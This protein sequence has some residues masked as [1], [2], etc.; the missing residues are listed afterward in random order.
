[1]NLFQADFDNDGRLDLLVLRG[2]WL[3]AEGRLRNSQLRNDLG[4]AENRFVDVTALAGLAYPAYP[5]QAAAWADYDSDG[6]LD[7]FIGNEAGVS[8]YMTAGEAE[9]PYPSQLFRNNGDGTFTDIA[10]RAGVIN[11]RFAK[12]AAWGDFDNDGDPDLYVSNFGPN[13]LFRNQ[14]DATFADVAEP[15]GVTEPAGGSFATW[16][17]DYDNDGW[18]DIFVADYSAPM[19]AIAASH[20]G[21]PTTG[22]HPILYRNTGDGFVDVSRRL[23][24]EKPHLPMGA[25][26]GDL[27]KDGWLDFYLGTGVPNFD[28]LMPNAMY[29]NNLG[30][31]FEDVSYAGGFAHLQKG[32]GVAFG[33]LDNDGDEDLFHQLGGA[34]PYDAYGNA[35]FANPGNGNHWLVLRLEGRQANRFGVGAR[36]T[37][38]LRESGSERVVHRV[39]GSGG[40][41]GGSSLQQEIGL[42]RATA[43]ERVIVDWPGDAR[44]SVFEHPDPD[45][46]YLAV[47]G[48]SELRP[49][50]PPRL[51]LGRNAGSRSHHHEEQQP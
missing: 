47:E 12:G 14:G 27:D 23:G 2:A 11:R 50:T 21:R 31:Q 4:G 36:I 5:T 13:R 20:F 35:L 7:L 33:D 41:F 39:V 19:A 9:D 6:D 32:H 38:E 15:L 26:F 34:F 49:L 30:R 28:A 18:L 24:L 42:G 3:G 22:G 46:F 48:E 45:R 1:L 37:V 8:L 29:R 25:N 10:R 16:F 44:R 51:Q 40:S 17:F 43:V